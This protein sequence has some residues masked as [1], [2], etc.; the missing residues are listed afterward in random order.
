MRQLKVIA[1]RIARVSLGSVLGYAD[2]RN[3]FAMKP[4]IRNA[5]ITRIA[6]IVVGIESLR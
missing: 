1:V 4:G 2:A 3:L 6:L 5:T